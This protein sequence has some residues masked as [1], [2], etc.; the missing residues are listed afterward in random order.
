MEQVLLHETKQAEPSKLP[1]RL[2]ELQGVTEYRLKSIIPIFFY[3][4][5]YNEIFEKLEALGWEELYLSRFK[6]D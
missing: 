1:K 5:R 2:I 3:Q 6:K 4:Q